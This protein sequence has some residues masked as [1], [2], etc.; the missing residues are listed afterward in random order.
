MARRWWYTIYVVHSS[1]AAGVRDSVGLPE[2]AKPLVPTDGKAA[3]VRSER[4]LPVE[5]YSRSSSRA[6]SGTAVPWKV[7]GG[8]AMGVRWCE[9]SRWQ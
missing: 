7:M 6:T 1:A 9:I 2:E 4:E 8:G 3:N 5:E